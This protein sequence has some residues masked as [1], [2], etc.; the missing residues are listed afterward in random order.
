[1]SKKDDVSNAQKLGIG[2]GLTTAAVAAAGAYFLYGSKNAPKNRKKIKSAVLKAKAEVLE[3]MENAKEITEDEFNEVVDTVMKSYSK[4]KSL[5]KKDVAEFRKEMQENW[6]GLVKSGVA[7]VVT[8]EKVAKKIIKKKAKKTA[9]KSPK[10]TTK[11]V[12]KKTTKKTVKK[13]A[14]RGVKTAKKK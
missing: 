12:A 14:R 9:K 4:A 10:K 5:S 11:K 7:K 2:V 6:N 8:V 1:M 3:V 13:T